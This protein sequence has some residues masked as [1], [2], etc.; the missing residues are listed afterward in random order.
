MP[1]I[2]LPP[3]VAD[4]FKQAFTRGEIDPEKLANMTSEE[5]HEFFKGFSDKESATTINSLFE[6]KLLLKNQ[7]KGMVT[8]AKSL[9]GM[10]ADAKRDLI[11]RITKMDKVLS[12]PEKDAFLKDLAATKLGVSVSHEEANAIAKLSQKMEAARTA[13]ESG[14]DRMAY[15]LAKVHLAN[16][17]NDLKVNADKMRASDFKHNPVGSTGKLLDRAAGNAKAIN[18][19]LDDSAIFRQGWKTLWTNP[20]IWQRN[21]RATFSNLVKQFGGHEV[22]D[23]VHADIVSRPN[24]ERM[25]KAKLDVGN[26]EESFPTS[27][28]EKIP[29]LGRVYKASE[30]AYTAFVQKQRAD[31]F[32]KYMNIAEKNGVNINDK[33]ELEAIGKLVNS[34]TGRGSLG[35]AEPV[36][37][38]VNNFFFSPRFVK[39]NID[40]VLQP[41]GAG[42]AKTAFARKQAALNLLKVASGSAAV[43]V[44]ANA[45]RPGSVE[46]DPRS[47]DFGKIRIGNTRFDV[48]GGSGSLATLTSRLIPTMADGK[49]G[50]HSKSATTK[51]VSTLNSGKFGATTGLDVVTDFLTNKA[52]PAASVVVDYLKG[53]DH[54]GNKPTVK[55]EA[56]NLYTPMGLKNWQELNADPHSANHLVSMI[57]DGLGIAS[58]TYGQSKGGMLKSTGKEVTDFK[59]KVGM[60]KFKQAA[61]DYDKKLNDNSQRIIN[62]PAY[63]K[64]STD[65][66]KAVMTKE[67]AKVQGQIFNQYDYKYKRAKPDKSANAK[68]KALVK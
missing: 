50:L 15:G 27:A 14:G 26:L 49:W 20:I 55:G 28:P 62:D 6:S 36:A 1:N 9:T 13:M 40:M 65:D 2:C 24:Y 7:Q 4:K 5:R 54:N 8:W 58:N 17:V 46:F 35:R 41:L 67:K 47:S 60:D 3:K 44:I 16:Y 63:K 11:T 12:E 38:L 37:G 56:A 39:S 57:A 51:Q 42:G 23:S 32:D 31:I 19:S 53:Q 59:D 68:I 22:M 61:A 29:V 33:T 48:S 52:S 21:A 18:A 34:L 30:A 64:L 25:V 45:V 43:M 66:Q 10:G